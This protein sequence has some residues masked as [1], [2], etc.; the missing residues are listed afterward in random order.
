LSTFGKRREALRTQIPIVVLMVCYTML[1]LW[2]LSQPIVET[3][4]AG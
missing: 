1:S 2:I 4:P 3:N